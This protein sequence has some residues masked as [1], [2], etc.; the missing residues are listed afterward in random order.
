MNGYYTFNF[1]GIRG[2]ENCG[3][4]KSRQTIS[5]DEVNAIFVYYFMSSFFLV[6][7]DLSASCMVC[8]IHG[9][10]IVHVLYYRNCVEKATCD[11]LCLAQKFTM[12]R[13]ITADYN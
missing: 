4:T 12:I 13:L 3:K 7:L 5:S 2:T 8:L 6:L 11:T 10:I 1:L 9:S